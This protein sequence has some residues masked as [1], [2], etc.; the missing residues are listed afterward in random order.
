MA[1]KKK[2]TKAP[3]QTKPVD[4]PMSPGIVKLV[5]TVNLLEAD[6]KAIPTTPTS[7]IPKLENKMVN[8]LQVIAVLVG[9]VG[10]DIAAHMRR[11][12][13]KNQATLVD[14]INDYVKGIVNGR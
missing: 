3:S 7:D 11:Q 8:E 1:E 4:P 2:T 10:R 14:D 9:Q 12:R 13:A 5:Q 6:F